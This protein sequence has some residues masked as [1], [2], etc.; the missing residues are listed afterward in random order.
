MIA[1]GGRKGLL[2][3][4]VALS[5]R[6]PRFVLIF[7]IVS[8]IVSVPGIV[9]LRIETATESVLDRSSEAWRFYNASEQM[10]GSDEFIVV[11]LPARGFDDAAVGAVIRQLTN[12]F[13]ELPGVRRV[14]SL[15]SVPLIRSRPGGAVDLSP[16]IQHRVP[17]ETTPT[18]AGEADLAHDR[19]SAR[20]LISEDGRTMAINILPDMLNPAGFNRLLT[21][22]RAAAEGM[23]ARIS[24]V[25]VFRLETSHRTAREVA[26][27]VP[28]TV[29]LMAL[30]QWLIFRSL[31][32]VLVSLGTSGL[33]TLMVVGTMGFLDV[34]LTIATM[35]LPSVLLAIGCAYSIHLVSEAGD[36][37]TTE[38]LYGRA[39]AVSRPLAL[40]GLTT[41]IGFAASAVV[42]IDAVREIGA[43]GA[44]GCF[45]LFMIV[46]TGGTAILALTVPHTTRNVLAGWISRVAAPA[47]VQL[48]VR[49]SRL[50]IAFWAVTLACLAIGLARIN[51]ETDVT[52]WFP[53]TGVV[54]AD[55][56]DIRSRLSGISPLNVVISATAEH[57]VTSSEAV[58]AIDALAS[59]IETLPD[60]GKVLSVA[61]PLR[62]LHG[63]FLGD[64]TQPLPAKPAEI[65]Q[66]LLL[67]ESVEQ[68]GDVLDPSERAA[69]VLIRANNNGSE[70]LL[71][72]ANEVQRWWEQNG[73]VGFDAR[74]TGIMFEFARA[75]H[76]IAF[77]QL[78]GLVWDIA[79]ISLVLL[80]VFRRLRVLVI[81]MIPNL[82]PVA[83][84]FGV[85]GL[86]QIPLDAGTVLV[87]TLAVGIAVDE[88]IHFLH[89]FYEQRSLGST[90]EVA[91][92]CAMGRVLPALTF[93]TTAVAIGFLV[94][95]ASDFVFTRN[96]G[97][98][99][100]GVMLVGIASNATLLPA[101]LQVAEHK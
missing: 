54:R 41:S 9:S 56:E 57:N 53:K 17:N 97:I 62:Q 28:A 35:I 100:A 76:E 65:A 61:D 95:A 20:S 91:L 86:A 47:L 21:G 38:E 50:V 69:N 96:L 63:G 98:L 81:A 88:T 94:L 39:L 58:A 82:V 24:G 42:P 32:P 55:Y 84:A 68:L 25:P 31:L 7:W 43:Y 19:L 64:R 51:V 40:A 8:G 52:L 33:G 23:E 44:L 67:L 1:N 85:I 30:L 37:R 36:A 3:L 59:H 4:L 83:G 15:A 73:I 12:Q 13:E 49:R 14:D 34:P 16:A 45:L 5:V 78:E 101:L 92:D 11:A 75:Q 27:F 90:S 71:S 66:Y 72:I 77:G 80:V 22:V 60:V 18:I 70:H 46:V 87:G 29:M 79:T 99:T 2:P 89:A 6:R 10:F 26:T 48:A 74:T 93:T